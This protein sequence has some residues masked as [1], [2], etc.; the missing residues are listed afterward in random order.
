M[1]EG[2]IRYFSSPSNR[3]VLFEQLGQHVY[4]SLVPLAAGVL[5]ALPLGR[6]AQRLR[7]LRAPLLGG[8]N[9]VYTVPSLAVFVLLPSVIGTGYTSPV[10]VVVA[11]TL[12]TT[13]LLLRPVLDALE[14]V[15]EHVTLAATAMGYR[16]HRRFLTVELPLAVPALTSAVRVAS[17]SNISL[18]SVGALI[19]IGGL[20]R[21]FTVGFPMPD[22]VRIVVG[23]VATVLLALAVDLLLVALWRLLTPWERAERR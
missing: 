3:E 4:L 21:L 18:V 13:A 2:L 17:V 9:V 1:F 14:A 22:T 19:G 6:L 23:I 8:A 20:G 10:N 5:L 16:T 7:W 11:L 15:P 12:Y